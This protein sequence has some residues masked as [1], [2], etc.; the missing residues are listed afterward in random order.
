MRL[1]EVTVQNYRSITSLTRFQVGDLTTLVGPNN[2]GKSNLLRAL[3]LSM[4]LIRRWSTIRPRSRG[5]DTNELTGIEAMSFTRR[6]GIQRAGGQEPIGFMWDRDYPLAKQSAASPRPTVLRLTFHL[7]DQEIQDFLA[8]TGIRNN[9]E[10]PIEIRL[11]KQSAS[12]GV[13]K[14]GP[15][16]ANH[17]AKAR[18]IAQFVSNLLEFVWVP[19]VRTGEQATT[20]AN[21]WARIRLREFFQS[22]EY[23]RKTEELN[24]MR[25]GAV[26]ALGDQIAESV[27]GYLP[28]VQ[29]FELEIEELDIENTIEDL[30]IDDGSRTRIAY[31]GDGVKSLVTMALIQELARARSSK[32][33]FILAV[34]EPEAHLHSAAVHELQG[35]FQQISST[36]QVILATHNPIFVNRDSVE[37]NVLVIGNEAKPARSV[38]QVRE[39]I[40]VRLYD[41]LESAEIVVMVEGVTDALSLPAMLGEVDARWTSAAAGRVAFRHT[42][43]TGRMRAQIQREK[44]SL[45]RIVVVLDNDGSGR[46]EAKQMAESGV[47]A[48]GSIFL[49]GDPDKRNSELEDLLSPRI[50]I[51]ALDIAFNRTFAARQFMRADKKWTENFTD[52]VSTLGIAGDSQELVDQAKTA[53]S[54]AV[55]ASEV[56]VLRDTARDHLSALSN[57]ILGPPAD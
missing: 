23:Q 6:T 29:G 46:V 10:L 5:G 25:R 39:A 42:A 50:Y 54:Q 34:D 8:S 41:N 33:S 47:L 3:S 22:E 45:S 14:K 40:G 11:G 57:V 12:F 28:S 20:L 27:R 24:T 16:S 18:E 35:L 1:T 2:E 4:E 43:G 48:P 9:G 17:Q 53:I 15:G 37:S 36:Q 13:V 32:G 56:S 51:P 31:K 38:L 49:L 7:D 55:K 19:A 21:T 44:L 52:A 30:I 26:A